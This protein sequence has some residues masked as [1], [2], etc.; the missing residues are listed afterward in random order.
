MADQSNDSSPSEPTTYNILFVCTGNTCRSPMA[1]AIARHEVAKRGWSHVSVASAGIMAG[2]GAPAAANAVRVAAEHEL[3]LSGH[4]SSPL[5]PELVEW[6]DLVL[7]MS[8]GHL[9][10]IHALGGDE[11]AALMTS[12]LAD[13]A[14]PESIADP[15]GADQEAYRYAFDE[16]R[17]ATDAVLTRLEPILAP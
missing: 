1:E 17:Q 10:A 15:Y 2:P 9:S 8:T 12:F 13:H 14:G 11:K 5:T 3:D 4:T 7:A 6:A 16:L